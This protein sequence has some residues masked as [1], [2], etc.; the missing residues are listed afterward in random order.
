[1]LR[2][3]ALV[4]MDEYLRSVYRLLVTV[5]VVPSSSIL[6]T[7]M[8]KELRS[9]ETPF[10]TRATRRHIPED[11]ISHSHRCEKPQILQEEQTTHLVP[12]D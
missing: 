3:V 4:M 7:L 6:V 11:G 10:L 1:M 2:R 5:N 8:M 9:S 12:S